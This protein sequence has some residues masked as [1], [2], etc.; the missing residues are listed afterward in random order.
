MI[1]KEIITG[2]TDVIFP[3]RCIACSAL[4]EEHRPLPFCPECT[5]GIR[6]IR[7]PLCPRCG[8]PFA[9]PE[10]EDRLCGG[11]LVTR[12]PFAL[13]RAVGLYE[14]TLLKAIHLFKYGRRIGIGKVLGSIMADFA[15]R[16]WE[17][18]DFSLIMPVP[19][20]R[21]RLQARGFNQA[22]ILAREIA[23][24]FAIPLDFLTMKR[25]RPTAPQVGLGQAERSA[26]VR[27][28]FTVRSRE[29]ISGHRILLVDDV[30]TTGNTLAECA[31]TLIDAGAGSVAVL[32]LARALSDHDVTAGPHHI[33]PDATM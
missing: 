7:S 8:I 12:L 23:K 26:N 14:A 9:A 29:G 10:A 31:G 2:I 33:S 3:P 13:A 20:H 19:L 17:M 22:V 25:Q 15:G 16:T 11:C 21:K 28:A 30:Y 1:L 6:Y 32:T 4:L 5:A 24:R 27:G 18:R